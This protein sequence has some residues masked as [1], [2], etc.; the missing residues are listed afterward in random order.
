[1]R[2]SAPSMRAILLFNSYNNITTPTLK[3]LHQARSQ[4]LDKASEIDPD[5]HLQISS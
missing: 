3:Y 1:M 2:Q 5:L 4:L